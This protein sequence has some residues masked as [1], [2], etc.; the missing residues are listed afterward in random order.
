MRV[1][2]LALPSID[3]VRILLTLEAVM[4]MEITFPAASAWTRLPA[5]FRS[6]PTNRYPRGGEGSA[7]DLFYAFPWRA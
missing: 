6:R 4:D 7:P 5:P 1:W 3:L 2:A